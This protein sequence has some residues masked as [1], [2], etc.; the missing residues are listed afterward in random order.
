VRKNLVFCVILGLL[1]SGILGCDKIGNAA[2]KKEKKEASVMQV[3][4]V[5]GP[6]AAKVNNIPIALADLNQEIEVYNAN[7]PEDGSEKKITTRD[8]KLNYLKNEMVRRMILYQAALDKGLDRD[9]NVAKAL[10][11]T[12]IQ[13]LVLELM[14]QSAQKVDVSS[15]DV[16]EFY[17]TYKEQFR[18]PEERKIQEI[19]VATEPE[20]K[21]ILIQL[22]QGAD[23][24]GLA[25]ASSIAAT[26][27][28]NGDLGFIKKGVKSSQFDAIA[29]SDSLQVG[30]TS[31]I[32]Q[33]PEGYAIIKLEAKR[34]GKQKLLSEAW[35][36]IK[37]GLTYL[38]Q[39]QAVDDLIGKLSRDAK[40]EIYEEQIK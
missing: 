24:S 29:F 22:L 12:K 30:K 37:Q 23:F 13:L 21:D 6:L 5:K 27:K 32:F 19:V 34:G 16:E 28:N 25:K 33:V 11:K 40:I 2:S 15:K 7:L 39:Q 1:F 3:S 18:D 9:E 8:E 10:E 35:E 38:K 14:R 31:N 17:N 4:Q 20:A 36:D 26:A